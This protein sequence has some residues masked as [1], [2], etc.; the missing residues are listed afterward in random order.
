MVSLH[1]TCIAEPNA[2]VRE[3]IL[4][5]VSAAL[6]WEQ[7]QNKTV[8]MTCGG[9]FLAAYM[10]KSFLAVNALQALNLNVICLVRGNPTSYARLA[11]YLTHPNLQIVQHDIAK[12]LA[13]DFPRADFIVH[14][15]SQASP[16]HYGTDPVG[17]LLANATGT[18]YLLEYAHRSKAQQFLFFSSGEV[19]GDRKSTRLNSSH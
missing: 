12:P 14:S 2:I 19:Y 7:L 13:I 5:I 9:G 8:L 15:A 16:R 10:L 18:Q 11:P 4:R 1:D 17:T 3:D 6:P